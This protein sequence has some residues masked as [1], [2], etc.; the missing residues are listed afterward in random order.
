MSMS[1]FKRFPDIPDE[2]KLIVWEFAL[3][4]TIVEPLDWQFLSDVEACRKTPQ[5]PGPR[6]SLMQSSYNAF[7]RQ[8]RLLASTNIRYQNRESLMSTC[9]L[10]RHL[11]LRLWKQEIKA[12]KKD[13]L[14]SV[15]GPGG[16]PA[17]LYGVIAGEHCRLLADLVRG[18]VLMILEEQ[19]SGRRKHIVGFSY[20]HSKILSY[21]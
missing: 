17:Q 15:L 21:E 2:I 20:A 12:I 3:V 13:V 14:V 10:S 19:L 1:S 11:A 4:P 8:A 7:I 9:Y 16:T 6:L 18:D 5:S